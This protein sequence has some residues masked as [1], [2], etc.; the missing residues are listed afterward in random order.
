[1]ITGYEE[2]VLFPSMNLYDTGMMQMYVNAAREQ[3]NQNREDMANFLKE[4]GSF[5][6]PISSDVTWVD[7]QTRGRV[8]DAINYLQQNGIDPLRSAEGRAVIQR[9]INSTDV[10]G[11]NAR[12]QSAENRKLWDK[13]A[14]ALKAEGK[15]NA[16]FVNWAFQQKYGVDPSQWSTASNGIWQ[17]TSPEIYQDLNAATKTWYDQMQPGYL[18]TVDGYDY[19]GNTPEDVAAIAKQN[20]PDLTSTYW[21]YQKELARRQL[22]PDATEDQINEQL[23]N[24]IVAAQ[25]EK[26]MRPTR[27]ENKE[28]ARA[29]EY[30]YDVAL[31]NVRTANDLEAYK[32]KQ[33]IEYAQK[34]KEAA[35]A[36]L[37]GRLEP[38]EIENYQ[39]AFNEALENGGY[40][41]SGV[42]GSRGTTGGGSQQSI[43]AAGPADQLDIQ[44]SLNYQQNKQ[45]A[46]GQY[47]KLENDAWEKQ[48]AIYET[49][50]DQQK[51]NA[52]RYGK[53]YRTLHNSKSSKSAKDDA[54]LTIEGLDRSQDSNFVK[55]RNQFN[56]RMELAQNKNRQWLDKSTTQGMAG[57]QVSNEYALH[58][59][60]H[61]IFERNNIVP[62]LTDDQKIALNKQLGYSVNDQNGRDGIMASNRDFADITIAKMTGDRSY[63]H[64]SPANKISRAIKNKEF[65]IE[66]K[67]ISKRK[68]GAG[69]IGDKRYNVIVEV[70]TFTD[71]DVV[72]EL[73]QLHED[74][75]K[76]FGIKS[77]TTSDGTKYYKIP[78]VSRF[79]HS[80]GRASVNNAGT[81]ASQGQ[82]EA[83][84]QL[85][86]QQAREITAN[87]YGQ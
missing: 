43:P 23:I 24:N 63:K 56:H 55:W 36:N 9:V 78:I 1:M 14:A 80:Q 3:Y 38:E 19:V 71:P 65:T 50:T 13:T 52:V 6:S 45:E 26:Y 76:H 15:Y 87:L 57:Y 66:A 34:A 72:A 39:A 51:K 54:R 4:Y 41:Y 40:A 49:L 7:Q 31:D 22:G 74:Q 64:N 79:G 82:S 37:N 44:Q 2:P 69:Y 33:D 61:A 48:K 11:I 16:D 68:Y 84:K 5:T 58:N 53:A 21:Q 25:A 60:S 17:E 46:I 75:L 83:G 73:D 29:Q 42:T 85:A 28:H 59:N 81:K 27:V 20:L 62:D 10:A 12:R 77:G 86:T 18:G 8:N 30:G 70:A 32:Q 47:E 67:D 35:D